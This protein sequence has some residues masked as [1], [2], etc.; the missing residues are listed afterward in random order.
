MSVLPECTCCEKVTRMYSF[1][2][3]CVCAVPVRFAMARKNGIRY[4]GCL[5]YLLTARSAGPVAHSLPRPPPVAHRRGG[6]KWAAQCAFPIAHRTCRTHQAARSS[7]ANACVPGLPMATLLKR[8]KGDPPKAPRGFPY[9]VG[10]GRVAHGARVPSALSTRT[11]A[12]V[13]RRKAAYAYERPSKVR[14]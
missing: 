14:G 11:K 9:Q 4:S 1:G 5:S 7:K 3:R 10:R 2:K 12:P 13:R 6:R 8:P